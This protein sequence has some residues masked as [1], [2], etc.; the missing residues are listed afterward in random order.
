MIIFTYLHKFDIE[1]SINYEKCKG[2]L[3]NF[4]RC[5]VC[6]RLWRNVFGIIHQHNEHD[7]DY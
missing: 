5:D 3:V 1:R 6:Y 4:A 2:F 7:L